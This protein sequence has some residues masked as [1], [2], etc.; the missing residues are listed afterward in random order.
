MYYLIFFLFAFCALVEMEKPSKGYLALL[1]AFFVLF[2]GLRSPY[3]DNDYLNYLGA[4]RKGWGIAE[5]SFFIISNFSYWLTNDTILVFIIYAAIGIT[6]QFYVLHR[7]SDSFWLSLAFFFS[8]YFVLLD[9]NAIRAGAALG[10]TMLSWKPWAKQQHAQALTL[11]GIASIFHYSFLILFIVYF[12]IK[13]NDKH[14]LLFLALIPLAYIIHFGMKAFAFFDIINN[15]IFQFKANA[16]NNTVTGELPVFSTVLILRLA[17]IS[18]LFYYRKILEPLCD[19]LYLLFKLYCVGFFISVSL[20]D[21]PTVAMRLLDIFACSELILLPLL[22]NI[23][24]PKKIAVLGVLLYAS[25]YFFIY[26]IKAQY[27]KPY[28]LIL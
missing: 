4:I 13:N 9:M 3:I 8:T 18:L 6:T 7:E 21:I 15:P 22:C 25:F 19:N 12:V 23:V 26:I 11:I 17:V 28:E 2:V 27:I 16:Y 14:I 1:I 20:A 10:F 24:K 5:Y